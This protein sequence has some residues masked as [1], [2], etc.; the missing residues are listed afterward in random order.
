MAV[1]HRHAL[2]AGAT[3]LVGR[4]LLPLLLEDS[5]CEQ[6]TAIGRRPPAGTHGKL[7]FIRAELEDMEQALAGGHWHDAFCCLGTTM[8]TAGSRPAFRAVDLDGVSAFA[9]AARTAGAEF[10][11]LVSAA[12][13]SS[14]SPSF[15]LRTKGEAEDA[16]GAVGFA[17]LAV[18]RPGVLVGERAEFRAAERLA[19]MAAP[20]TDRLLVGA[21]AR[22]RSVPAATVAAALLAAAR[23]RRPG[24]RCLDPEAMKRLAATL[25]ES[26]IA[27]GRTSPAG[28]TAS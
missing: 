25:A 7:K 18:M 16:V 19:A 17:S 4:S 6:V 26:G 13:A 3:G 8:K 15:Y 1:S 22:Y 11:G 10:F 2:I 14:E 21:L 12:G 9:R 27:A 5:A 20:V 23:E 28:G 24:T